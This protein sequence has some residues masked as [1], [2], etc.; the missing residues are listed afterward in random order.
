MRSLSVCSL[1]LYSQTVPRRALLTPAFARQ[2]IPRSL[3]G[4]RGSSKAGILRRRFSFRSLSRVEYASGARYLRLPADGVRAGYGV[5]SLCRFGRRANCP[6]IYPPHHP[7]L[8]LDLPRH[9][10]TPTSPQALAQSFVRLESKRKPQAKLNLSL[11]GSRVA[12]P[13]EP[14]DSDRRRRLAEVGMVGKVKELGAEVEF[15]FFAELERL[16]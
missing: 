5:F 11:V 2:Q 12:D 16:E 13:P 1:S 8:A 9:T 7:A 4:I 6:P 10:D 15:S 14:S 3:K